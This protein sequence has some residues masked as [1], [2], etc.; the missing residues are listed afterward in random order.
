[1]RANKIITGL[2]ATTTLL[3]LSCGG[4]ETR[5]AREE[6]RSEPLK[7]SVETVK[8]EEL[9]TLLESI[10]TVRSQVTTSLA[11]RL[12]GYVTAVSVNEGDQ[13]RRGQLMAQIDSRETKAQLEGAEAGLHEAESAREETERA[14]RASESGLEAAQANAK[15]AES[16]YRRFEELLTRK[17]V[18]Q[19]EFDEVEARYTAAQAEFRRSE[20]MLGSVEAKAQQVEARVSQAEAALANARLYHS[21]SHITSPMNGLVISKNVEVGQL[22]SPGTPLFTVEDG[23]NYRLDAAVEESRIRFI[24]V[25]QSL[26]VWVDALGEGLRGKVTEIVPTADP[27]SRSF[28]VKIGLPIH[29]Q[30][31]SGLFGRVSFPAEMRRSFTVPR[32]CAVSRGQ[33]TGVYVVDSEQKAR[34][35]LVKTGKE[36]GERVEILS[37]LKEGDQ[38]VVQPLDQIQE[39]QLLS[40]LESTTRYLRLPQPLGN[41]HPRGGSV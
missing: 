17:S 8:I 16:T 38:V 1:M 28:T 29:P 15:L 32:A 7:V 4:E 18:S 19:Q 37:G 40:V 35:Q 33:L 10:G 21:Y 39:G 26:T 20:E 12:M 31:R 30:L 22:A 24:S 2:M 41:N 14:I 3:S 11:S 27:A 25:S 13:V 23:R 6:V 36:I 5:R 9:A 34:F